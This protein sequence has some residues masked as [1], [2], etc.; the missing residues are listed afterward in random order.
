MLINFSTVLDAPQLES[1]QGNVKNAFISREPVSWFDFRVRS[2]P[3]PATFEW[4]DAFQAQ[5]VNVTN[6]VTHYRVSINT[7][8]FTEA[9]TF[10]VTGRN[11]ENGP[12]FSTI[13]IRVESER[14]LMCLLN[15]NHNNAVIAVRAYF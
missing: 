14:E 8:D 9:V 4:P 3:T 10:D 5:L 7:A 6:D 11:G 1:D 13:Q 12:L 15:G 2:F